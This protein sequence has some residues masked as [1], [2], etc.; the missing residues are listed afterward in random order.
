M[1]YKQIIWDWNGTLWNDTWLC[2]EINNHMLERRGLPLIQPETYRAKLCFPVTDYY[3]QLGFD[4]EVDPYPRLAEEFIAEY[5]QRRFECDLH[6]EVREL[7]QF[8]QTQG[9]LQSVLSAYEQKALLESTDYFELTGFFDEI[10]GLNDI[11]AN[12]KV[13]NGKQYIANSNLNPSE[14]LF[15]G[16]TVHDFEVADAMGV[17]CALVAN[18]HNSRPRLEACG[19]PVF[20]SLSGVR[21]I[22]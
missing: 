1:K 22:A 2:V 11:Y 9:T 15:V 10:I 3:C 20:N 14:V 4:Y 6:P 8:F 17:Q 7:I 16:D 19:V 12:G 13:E 18:G 21:S 5:E